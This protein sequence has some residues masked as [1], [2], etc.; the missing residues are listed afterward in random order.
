MPLWDET[1]Q[2]KSERVGSFF[3]VF[4]LT[5]SLL[6]RLLDFLCMPVG[7]FLGGG[8]LG[9]LQRMLDLRI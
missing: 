5:I 3:D 8:L 4:P 2:D 6:A 9:F 7:F 1:G